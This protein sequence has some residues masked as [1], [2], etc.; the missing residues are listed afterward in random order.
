MC[1]A[2]TASNLK[3]SVFLRALCG[4]LLR[5]N[6][7]DHPTGQDFAEWLN[8]IC[9]DQRVTAWTPRWRVF[10]LPRPSVSGSRSP[11]VCIGRPDAWCN[12]SCDSN[13]VICPLHRE[14]FAAP[15]DVILMKLKY[16]EEGGS[17]KH[18]RDIR[19]V[20]TVQGDKIDRPYITAWAKRLGVREEW[21]TAQSE[22]QNTQQH[23]HRKPPRAPEAE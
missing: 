13:T 1:M 5:R 17:E 21:L 14:Q 9:H 20:L 4:S 16:Y 3:I 23:Q 10:W 8:S 19:S 11:G 12:A 22:A 15:E 6:Q 7:L 18:L 2:P